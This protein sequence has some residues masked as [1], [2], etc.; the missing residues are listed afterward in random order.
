MSAVERTQSISNVPDGHGR[1]HLVYGRH[2]SG[3]TPGKPAPDIAPPER[4]EDGCSRQTET[5]LA[6]QNSGKG[7]ELEHLRPS[8]PEASQTSR[9]RRSRHANHRG[10]TVS[11]IAHHMR[12]RLS[13]TPSG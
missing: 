4:E 3:C 11:A 7:R 2:T 1:E 5:V 9:D 8:N 6:Q 12:H 10:A 13:Y